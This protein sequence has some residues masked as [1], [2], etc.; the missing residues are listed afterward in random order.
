MQEAIRA[1]SGTDGQQISK[2]RIC[3]LMKA[4][5]MKI[6]GINKFYRII[7][8]YGVKREQFIRPGLYLR[9]IRQGR[10]RFQIIKSSKMKLQH[11][12]AECMVKSR[13]NISPF[14]ILHVTDIDS[15]LGE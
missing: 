9:I 14:G 2:I 12:T 10:I 15:P 5:L 7:R 11:V 3:L 6:D 13:K 4:A 8:I 1:V